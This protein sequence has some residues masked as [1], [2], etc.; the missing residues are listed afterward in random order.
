MWVQYWVGKIPYKRAW[1]ST[2]VFLPREFHGQRSLTGYNSWGCE[3]SAM[4]E[5]L[6]L[7]LF[8]LCSRK[9][10]RILNH[11]KL[12]S[13]KKVMTEICKTNL[14]CSLCFSHNCTLPHPH[15]SIFCLQLKTVFKVVGW[16]HFKK[17]L[18]FLGYLKCTREVFFCYCLVFQSCPALCNSMDCSLPGSSIHGI[19]QARVLKWAVIYS[20]RGSSRPR[21]QTRLS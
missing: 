12:L 7:S 21:D 2:P 3:E 5:Q 11:Q 10:R 16:G 9:R 1:Q 8:F 4:T 15:T 18:S 17:L 13:M 20:S 19:F 6:T 14:P